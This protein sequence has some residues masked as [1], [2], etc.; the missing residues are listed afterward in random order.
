MTFLTK[1][2]QLKIVFY[3]D[4]VK[5]TIPIDLHKFLTDALTL[6]PDPN[7][8]VYDFLK[9]TRFCKWKIM[10][11]ML[12]SNYDSTQWQCDMALLLNLFNLLCFSKMFENHCA[13]SK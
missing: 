3:S 5:E 10:L 11:T 1:L 4:S 7:G 9:I 12:T 8:N 2:S 6:G 13:N